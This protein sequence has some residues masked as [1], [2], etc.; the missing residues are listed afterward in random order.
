[1]NGQNKGNSGERGKK[2]E[3]PDVGSG[4]SGDS[5]GTAAPDEAT[6]PRG[7][8]AIGRAI[9]HI[10]DGGVPEHSSSP[11]APTTFV[12]SFGQRFQERRGVQA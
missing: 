1:M 12:K 10:A 8:I 11:I 6:V 9:F 5:G 3:T 2:D 4:P 7:E